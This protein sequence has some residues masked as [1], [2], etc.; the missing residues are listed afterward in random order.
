MFSD[1]D[2]LCKNK[3]VSR[4]D[5]INENAISD[6]EEDSECNLPGT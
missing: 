6:G 3:R 1:G 4:L 5:F 2:L